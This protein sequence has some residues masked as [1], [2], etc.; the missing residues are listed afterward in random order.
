MKVGGCLSAVEAEDPPSEDD[1]PTIDLDVHHPRQTVV[2]QAQIVADEPPRRF[3]STVRVGA[4]PGQRGRP[5]KQVKQVRRNSPTADVAVLPTP[6]KGPPKP[7]PVAQTGDGRRIGRGRKLGFVPQKRVQAAQQPAPVVAPEHRM[8]IA[9][10]V[11]PKV[12]TPLDCMPWDI[13]A[14]APPSWVAYPDAQHPWVYVDPCVL[15][16]R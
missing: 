5:P 2:P 14:S 11:E 8:Q 12:V 7:A 3:S 10:A 1:I 4:Q 6:T 15:K 16:F 13:R 9:A